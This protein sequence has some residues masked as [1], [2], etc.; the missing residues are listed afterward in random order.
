MQARG[1]VEPWKYTDDASAK[2]LSRPEFGVVTA[3]IGGYRQLFVG[4]RLGRH[5]RGPGAAPCLR[6]GF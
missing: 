3:P 5:G 4:A 1:T 2:K 6:R